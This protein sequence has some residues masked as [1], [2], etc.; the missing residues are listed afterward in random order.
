MKIYQK[1]VN[2]LIP[3]RHLIPRKPFYEEVL[4]IPN[5]K[6]DLISLTSRGDFY[7]REYGVTFNSQKA[8]I[9][10]KTGNSHSISLSL[11]EYFDLWKQSKKERI[12]F[13]HNHPS[14][15][16]L[17]SGDL[18]V[19]ARLGFSDIVA[20]TTKQK[21]YSLTFP[22]GLNLLDKIRIELATR[23]SRCKVL[24][25]FAKNCVYPAIKAR[26]S[27]EGQTK[28]LQENLLS[29]VKDLENKMEIGLQE[30]L[31]NKFMCKYREFHFDDYK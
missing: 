18:N 31:E 26:F 14:G 8:I 13:F 20:L 21:G 10:K 30:K 2:Y 9:L 29:I 6:A 16:S 28:E 12:S 23:V 24:G 1:F 27:K 3:A 5:L 15:S 19:A 17:S 4:E 7:E 25:R 11:K 22:E